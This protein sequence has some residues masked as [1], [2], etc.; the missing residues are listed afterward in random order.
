MHRSADGEAL[1][2]ATHHDFR[3]F[4]A[5][6]KRMHPGGVYLNW[7][8]AVILPE[9]FLKAVSVARN[10]G[11][12]LD[13]ITTANFD[14]VQHYRPLQNVIQRPTAASRRNR[15]RGYAIT[16][17]HEILMPLIAAALIEGIGR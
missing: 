11:T 13:P 1:G 8:S 10:L 2:A 15:S 6:V 12:P 5:L 16:G 9:I 7:G 4:C 14:F 3:L 17:H